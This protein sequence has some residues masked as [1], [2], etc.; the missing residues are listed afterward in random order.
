MGIS[1]EWNGGKLYYLVLFNTE[2]YVDNMF[3]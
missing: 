1:D 3:L 2:F